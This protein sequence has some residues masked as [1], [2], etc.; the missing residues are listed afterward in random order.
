VR[1]LYSF[2]LGKQVGSDGA[3]RLEPGWIHSETAH[4]TP[5]GFGQQMR[6]AMVQRREHHI[7]QGDTTRA[8]NGR[9]FYRRRLLATPREREVARVGAEIA[10][11]KELPFRA[12]PDSENICGEFAATQEMALLP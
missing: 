1:V 9:L 4:V 10:E 6:E 7:E 2:D 12:A 3:T 11:S 8:R 5:T